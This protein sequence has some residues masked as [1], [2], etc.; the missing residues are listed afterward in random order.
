MFTAVLPWCLH[1]M[2]QD[3]LDPSLIDLAEDITSIAEREGKLSIQRLMTSFSKSRFRTKDD[4]LRQAVGCLR[5]H[6]LPSNGFRVIEVLLGFCLNSRDWMREK[7]MLILKLVFQS[8]E[9]KDPLSIYGAELLMPLLRLLN[10]D[11]AASALEVLSE[12]I[13]IQGGPAAA[14]VI[15]MSMTFGAVMDGLTDNA[16]EVFGTPLES[17]WCVAKAEEQ[18]RLARASML[19]VFDSL[20]VSG[21]VQSQAHFSMFAEPAPF[22][23]N[24][25]QL[26]LESYAGSIAE[27]LTLGQLVGDLHSLNQ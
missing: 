25:S 20:T 21:N 15:R 5:E 23:I 2:D 8:P 13:N 18:S 3:T 27:E 22:G 6:F 19:A 10:T 26:S 12:P 17:G 1:G 24:G 11:F 9:A 16:G 7:T 14:Q 4:F